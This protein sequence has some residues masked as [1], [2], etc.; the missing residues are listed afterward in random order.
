VIIAVNDDEQ[1]VG[2]IAANTYIVKG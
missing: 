1:R 2:D